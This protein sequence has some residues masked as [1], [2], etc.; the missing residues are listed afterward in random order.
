M[1]TCPSEP[2]PPVVL[3]FPS[4]SGT[5]RYSDIIEFVDVSLGDETITATHA[6]D[7]VFSMDINPDD[8]RKLSGN[9][10]YTDDG[11][12]LTVEPK[13]DASIALQLSELLDEDAPEYLHDQLFE[14]SFG[15]QPAGKVLLRADPTCLEVDSA[16]QFELVEG[17]F[18][19]HETHRADSAENTSSI[20]ESMCLNQLEDNPDERF[21]GT[22]FGQQ[23]C[24]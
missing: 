12:M 15:A 21:L 11:V 10:A 5:F 16:G 24:E 13:L 18:S 1:K 14:L 4:L 17:P 9:I 3:T 20:D 19:L 22:R 6:D 23:V 2:D 8:E 7:A